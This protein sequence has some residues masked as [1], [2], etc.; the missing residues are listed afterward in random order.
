VQGWLKELAACVGID[1]SNELLSYML[2][3]TWRPQLVPVHASACLP[4]VDSPMF[5]A[6]PIALPL[7]PAAATNKLR[8]L[9]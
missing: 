6:L 8:M 9:W 7:P 1:S 3:D 4:G 5:Y 2:L